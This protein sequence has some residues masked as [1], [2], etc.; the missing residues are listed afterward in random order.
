MSDRPLSDLV[1]QGWEV[2]GY[3]VTDSGGEAWKHNF[4]LRRQGQHK[5]LTVRKKMMGDGVVAS[6][7]EV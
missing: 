1:R 2:A 3:T 6:E 4:L 7:M 5:V